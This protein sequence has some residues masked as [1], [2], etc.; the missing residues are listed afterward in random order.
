MIDFAIEHAEIV[1]DVG[2]FENWLIQVAESHQCIISDITYV[3]TSDDRL[4]DLNQTYLKHDYYTDILTFDRT[5]GKVLSG[6]IYISLDRVQ[7]NAKKFEV[8]FQDELQRVMA[9]GIL[10]MTGLRDSN[11]FERE[12]MRAAEDAAMKLFHVKQ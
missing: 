5:E 8:G 11:D 9:H 1:P 7:E 2:S 3:L 6:D 12:R 4:L 10:H